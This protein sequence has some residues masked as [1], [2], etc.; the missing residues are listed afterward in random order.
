MARQSLYVILQQF[1]EGLAQLPEEKKR[2]LE[3]TLGEL[4]ASEYVAYMNMQA[5]MHASGLITTD[6][7]MILYNTIKD[8]DDADLAS[9]YLTTKIIAEYAQIKLGKKGTTPRE[10]K[11]NRSTRKRVVKRRESGGPDYELVSKTPWFEGGAGGRPFRYVVLKWK[12]GG[13]RYEYSRHMEV[14]AGEMYY[15]HYYLDKRDAIADMKR[16]FD[17][18]F[19]VSKLV[20]ERKMNK[21]RT[22]QK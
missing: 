20:K 5:E 18:E 3:K 22:K 17:D 21:T 15:G 4:D 1:R 12:K 2:S 9:R 16:S 7:A 19:M 14:G 13:G 6:D 11:V 8:W 10:R